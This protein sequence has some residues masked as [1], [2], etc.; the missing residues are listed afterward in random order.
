MAA[1]DIRRSGGNAEAFACDVTLQDGVRVTLAS[2][3]D[4]L[5]H[6]RSSSTTLV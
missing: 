2:V 1:D 3:A 4:K 5:G 6:P